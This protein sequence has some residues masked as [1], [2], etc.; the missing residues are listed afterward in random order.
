MIEKGLY[1]INAPDGGFVC[2]A[3]AYRSAE[4]LRPP[5]TLAPRAVPGAPIP[6]ADL[7]T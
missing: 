3:R 5:A 6:V 7:L 1:V 2:L 4:I